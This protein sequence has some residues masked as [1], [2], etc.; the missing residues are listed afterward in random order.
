MGTSYAPRPRVRGM[1]HALV[2]IADAALR[3]Q[4]AQVLDAS[5]Y[6]VQEARSMR[7]ALRLIAG[8]RKPNV[9]LVVAEVAVA[10]GGASDLAGRLLAADPHLGVVLLADALPTGDVPTVVGARRGAVVITPLIP[11]VLA[12]TIHRLVDA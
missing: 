1:G 12:Q 7:H 9:D 8:H 11:A 2:V 3:T 6:R 10:P 4:A 5:G